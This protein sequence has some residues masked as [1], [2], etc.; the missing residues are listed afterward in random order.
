MAN[1]SELL[2]FKK[3]IRVLERRFYRST[4]NEILERL[5][6]LKLMAT[7]IFGDNIFKNMKDSEIRR[8]AKELG[9]KSWYQKGIE[10]LK[11]EI[12]EITEK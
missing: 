9:I 5:D 3:E 11:K 12:K 8:K 2:K 7:D 4:L 1:N 6:N 10:K